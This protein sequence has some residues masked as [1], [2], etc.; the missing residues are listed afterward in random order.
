MIKW[1][2]LKNPEFAVR[3]VLGSFDDNCFCVIN[4]EGDRWR[5]ILRSPSG[6]YVQVFNTIEKAKQSAEQSVKLGIITPATV[7]ELHDL[8]LVSVIV[9]RC[10][11]IY[12]N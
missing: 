4:Y 8:L 2:E 5:S 11:E 7:R 12:I 1:T 6:S 9:A 10:G 3:E